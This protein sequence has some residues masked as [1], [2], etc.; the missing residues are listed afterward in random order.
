[1]RFKQRKKQNLDI[2]L[3][4]GPIYVVICY[5]CLPWLKLVSFFLGNHSHIQVVCSV[6]AYRTS[7]PQFLT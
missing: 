4:L 2:T 5:C 6:L 3:V 1:M 7:L